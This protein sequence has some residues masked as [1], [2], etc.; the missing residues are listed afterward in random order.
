[1]TEGLRDPHG[2]LSVADLEREIAAGEAKEVSSTD[3]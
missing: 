1:M 3:G 2:W